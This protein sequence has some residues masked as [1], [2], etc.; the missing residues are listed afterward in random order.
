MMGQ[1]LTTCCP[2]PRPTPFPLHITAWHQ[3]NFCSASQAQLG[4]LV[5]VDLA[6]S[7]RAGKTGAAGTTLAEGALI[8][9]SLSCLANVIHALTDTSTS[10][11][12][13]HV[14]YR[15]SKLTRMLQDSLVSSRHSCWVLSLTTHLEL[16]V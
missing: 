5:L 11:A 13:R 6:G 14:P 12:P 16:W 3:H 7:E 10:S 15:D 9:K 8:N 1:L 4:K 2:A